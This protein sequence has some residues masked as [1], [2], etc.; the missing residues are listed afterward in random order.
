SNSG[1]LGLNLVDNDSIVDIAS[2]PLGGSGLVNGDY[3]GEVYAIDNVAPTVVSSLRGSVSP[4]T[5]ASVTFTVTFSEA[6]TGV[7]K[8]DF[9]LNPTVTGASITTVTG[10]GLTRTVTVNT[11]TGSGAIRLNVLDND[12][13][14]DG[15]FSPL[16]GLKTGTTYSAGESYTVRTGSFQKVSPANGATGVVPNPTLSWNTSNTATSYEYCIDT[17]AGTTCDSVAGWV[18]TGTAQSVSLSGLSL[19][20]TYYW[21]VRSA[22]HGGFAYANNAWWSFTVMNPILPGAFSKSA[23]ADALAGTSR[24][25]ALS[26]AASSDAASY[27]YCIDTTPGT[28]C[29]SVAG[30]VST[31]TARTVT[32]AG[33]SF[34]TTY[35]WQVR[36][37][38]AFGTTESNSG[39]WWNYST[40]PGTFQKTSP[41]NNAT[42]VTI[43]PTLSWNS[44]TGAASYEYCIDTT[45]GTTCDS[46][47]GWVSTGTTRNAALSGLSTST[48]YYWQV[49][50]V[51][52]GGYSYA[53]T[54]TWWAFTTSAP[55]LP[56][57]FGKTAPVDAAAGLATS[58][59]LSWGSSSNVTSYQYC[60]DTTPGS[61]CD[62]VAGWVS[63]GTNRNVAPSG[64]VRGTIYYWQ[65]RAVNVYGITEANGGTWWTFATQ[66][67]SFQKVSPVNG[68]TNVSINPTLSW[69]TS[70]GSTAYEYCI[71]TTAGSTCDSVAGW[72]SNGT[73]LSVAL[74]GL[75]NGTT[76][77]WQVRSVLAGG[78]YNANNAWWSFTTAP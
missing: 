27:E 44:S 52:A 30:W 11:G 72:V 69:N 1:T 41:T 68:A 24:T 18:S 32:P 8:A 9:S 50:S 63:T 39:T 2:I 4:T 78:Y 3:T 67:G 5:A 33:L 45:P 51:F 57:A 28:T 34:A 55:I 62:S 7:D 40:A 36:A 23:P 43:A 70:T 61:T 77:Y 15:L 35:Y 47:A 53:N 76:Y 71:D 26:W 46:V 19:S 49:R 20:T 66:P 25:Q 21:Q 56:G 65:I 58:Q 6:V 75:S 31:G 64:L 60:I 13:I 42:G 14:V 74:S 48:T 73:S 16:N 22:L 54:S 59:A 12:S 38:N 17:T 37:L 10:T 29:D